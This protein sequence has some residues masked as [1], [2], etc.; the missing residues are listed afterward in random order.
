[1]FKYRCLVV[2][3]ILLRIFISSSQSLFDLLNISWLMKSLSFSKFN[4]YFVSRASFKDIPNLIDTSQGGS[5]TRL[6]DGLGATGTGPVS[7]SEILNNLLDAFTN[8]NAAPSGSG[9]SGSLTSSELAAGI[10]SVIGEARVNADAV[11][12]TSLARAS[13]LADA[14]LSLTGVD[15]DA[16][17]QSLLLIEQSYAANARVI[18]TISD[19]LDTLMQI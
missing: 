4:Q 5:A 17:I 6:R 9:L 1:M 8:S 15:T 10:S 13:A 11:A 2:I 18:Q 16:E 19:M 14:E 3:I 12:T 7:N